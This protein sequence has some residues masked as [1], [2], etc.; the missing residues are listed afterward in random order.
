MQNSNSGNVNSS[1]NEKAQFH[2]GLMFKALEYKDD[3]QKMHDFIAL[4][5]KHFP[6][7]PKDHMD[8]LQI[9]A[10]KQT[11]QKK[12]NAERRAKKAEENAKE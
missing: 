12:A 2:L 10:T 9:E 11:N 7:I 4:N 8:K 3:Y 5:F 1:V 6:G